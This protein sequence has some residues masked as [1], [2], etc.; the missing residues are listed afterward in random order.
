[1]FHNRMPYIRSNLS[2]YN[3][4]LKVHCKML[5]TLQKRIMQSSKFDMLN[6]NSDV[7]NLDKALKELIND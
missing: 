2:H 1:M 5:S 6:L 7:T 4:P 3:K